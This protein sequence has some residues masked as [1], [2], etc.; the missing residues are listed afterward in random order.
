[1]ALSEINLAL[2]LTEANADDQ[3]LDQLTRRL[4]R[5]LRDLG[6]E[7]VERPAGETAPEGAKGD[8]ITLGALALAVLPALLPKLVE[9][10]QAWAGRGESRVVKIK[11]PSGVEIEFTPGKRLSEGEILSVVEQ[12]TQANR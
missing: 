6:A 12:L 9:L 8:P 2:T 4:M 10:L 7:S 3:T 5:D 1:M 11:T